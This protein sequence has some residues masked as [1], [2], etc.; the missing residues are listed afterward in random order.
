MRIAIILLG[1]CA[2]ASG[3]TGGIIN[4]VAGT[5]NFLYNGDNIPAIRANMDF[6]VGDGEI[7]FY[8]HLTL[9]DAGNIFI[10]DTVNNRVRKVSLDGIITTVA[11]NGEHSFSG[12]GG[13]ATQAALDYPTSVAFDRSGNLHIADQHNSR[14]RRVGAD[15]IITTLAGNGSPSLSGNGGPATQAALA[16]PNRSEERRVGK[17]CRL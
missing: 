4:T 13:L 12:T 16:Y 7:E 5:G 1:V 15:G 14:I 2:I 3:Q 8:S 6:G 9:D 10:P 17:E 11:G